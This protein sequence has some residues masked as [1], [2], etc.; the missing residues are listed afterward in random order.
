VP[1]N[2][3]FFRNND[4]AANYEIDNPT[5]STILDCMGIK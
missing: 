1:K 3:L 4:G 2:K 5:S